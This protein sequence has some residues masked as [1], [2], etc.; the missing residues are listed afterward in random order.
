MGSVWFVEQKESRLKVRKIAK[1]KLR[2]KNEHEFKNIEEM[3]LV[4]AEDQAKVE[5]DV[6][7][8]IQESLQ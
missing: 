8:K 7:S 4:E 3:C 6:G 2:V 5:K 1:Q